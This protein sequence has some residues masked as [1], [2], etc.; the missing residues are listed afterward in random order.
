M[1]INNVNHKDTRYFCIV[2]GTELTE[3]YEASH[4]DHICLSCLEHL[5]QNKKGGTQWETKTTVV[6]RSIQFKYLVV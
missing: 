5:K 3:K 6:K 4:K 1:T 2:C